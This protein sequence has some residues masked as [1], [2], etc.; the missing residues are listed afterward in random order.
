MRSKDE[1]MKLL[2]QLFHNQD[3]L[4]KWLDSPQAQLGNKTPRSVM[5]EGGADAVFTLVDLIFHGGGGL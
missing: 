5:E 1:V 3:D 4:D 2:H